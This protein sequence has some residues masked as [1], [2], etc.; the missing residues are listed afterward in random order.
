MDI[1]FSSLAARIA[2][3]MQDLRGCVIVSRD[4]L[5]LGSHP[6][7]AEN[8]LRPAWLRFAS[9]GDVEKGFIQFSG[10]LW[11]YVRRGPYASFAVSNSVSRPGLLL[12]ELEQ[13]LLAA[14]EARTSGPAPGVAGGGLPASRPRTSL[15]PEPR[16]ASTHESSRAEAAQSDASFAELTA[17]SRFDAAAEEM[18][19][20]DITVVVGDSSTAP[21]ATPQ[22]PQSTPQAPQAMP[23]APQTPPSIPAAPTQ[24]LYSQYSPARTPAPQPGGAPAPEESGE[25]DRVALAQEFAQLLGDSGY[26]ASEED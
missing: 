12:D 6:A 8:I 20:D 17:M 25:V 18:G 23:Q 11:V 4:G 3:D 5:V 26:D 16:P 13:V 24:D 10:E 1:D 22:A 7:D 19:G 14:E 15:H 9:L 21:M 2:S